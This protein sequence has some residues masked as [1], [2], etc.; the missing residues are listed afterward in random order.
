MAE[1]NTLRANGVFGTL[2]RPPELHQ[3]PEVSSIK[4]IDT[5]NTFGSL[6]RPPD[7]MAA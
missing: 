5:G 6:P 1:W 2:P 7:Y 3:L 4:F